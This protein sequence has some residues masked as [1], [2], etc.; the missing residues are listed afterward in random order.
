MGIIILIT[1]ILPSVLVAL[2]I[3]KVEEELEYKR[4]DTAI[5]QSREINDNRINIFQYKDKEINI[6]S[7]S[8]NITPKDFSYSYNNIYVETLYINNNPV[9]SI[10]EVNTLTKYHKLILNNE[11]DITELWKILKTHRKKYWKDLMLNENNKKKSI[12]EEGA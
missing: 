4:V 3:M 6:K 7:E 9:A 1:I 8:K 11:Y 10:W 2:L 12:I 5:W